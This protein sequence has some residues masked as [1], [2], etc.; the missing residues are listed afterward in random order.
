MTYYLA[1]DI[2]ASGGRHIL[3]GLNNGRLELE[4]V[5]RF[6]NGTVKKNGRLCWDTDAL[7]KEIVTGM[8]K[9][10]EIGKIPQSVGIDTWAVD[11]VLLD[12]NGKTLG[13]SVAYRDSRTN[14]MDNVLSGFISE[15][16]LYARTGIQKQPFNTVYQLLAL[17]RQDPELLNQAESL[18][19]IPEYFS[20]LLSGK[21]MSEYTNATT[22]GLVNAKS[23]NWDF[24][25][26]EALKLPGH[27]FGEL[28]SPGASLGALL[29]EIRER[30]GYDCNVVLPCTHD[31]ASA[32]VSAPVDDKSLYLSSGTWSLLG[33]ELTE[34]VCTEESRL[35]NMTNEGGYQYRYRYLKNIMGLWMIQN[36]KQEH[37]NYSFDDLCA[38][39]MKA[40]D[41]PSRVDVNDNRFL[42]PESMESEI[43]A[44]CGESGQALPKDIGELAFCIYQSLAD[45]YDAA[46]KEIEA[47]T[48]TTYEKICIV[49]GGS[50]D[51]YLNEL[52]KAACGKR[53]TAGPAEGTAAG[54]ILVQ[55][56][57]AG[58]IRSL[59]DAREIVRDSF[60]I[61][62]Y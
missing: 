27:I 44:A 28:V 16:E 49:G 1:V 24:D 42:A 41:F 61:V 21:H 50:K 23:K 37:N 56:L 13:D 14:G 29:P 2:G 25:L 18:L 40:S 31:T 6:K 17:Q 48:G 35:C 52:T 58:E 26:I 12:K 45:S 10:R 43:R 34:P 3:G 55:M 62:E 38:L 11:F 30:V 20:Y 47:L 39:A 46:V 15:G 9:C 36:I 5:H 53:V 54:N 4:E 19:M 57:S 51:T 60:Q 8:I 32:V 7:M 59:D 33:A 22:T